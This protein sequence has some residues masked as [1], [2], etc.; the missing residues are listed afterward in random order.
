MDVGNGV[1]QF[2]RTILSASVR[3]VDPEHTSSTDQY[4]IFVFE[5]K[6]LAFLYHQVSEKSAR[7]QLYDLRGSYLCGRCLYCGEFPVA[8]QVRCM[9]ALLLLIG[10][11]LE[12]PEIID[13]LL[14]VQ[15]NPRKPQ[16]RYIHVLI[17]HSC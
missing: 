10:Q 2:E 11:K 3:P 13:Q 1:L 9:M 7:E 5:V 15:S 14:D 12:A 16:Y 6:G 8:P 17:Q 4:D